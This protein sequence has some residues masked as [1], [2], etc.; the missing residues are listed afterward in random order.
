M[1]AMSSLKEIKAAW[2]E[3]VS[4]KERGELHDSALRFGRVS[5]LLKAEDGSSRIVQQLS[6]Q[7]EV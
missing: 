7:V 5:R 3:A 6:A 4:L 2:S 1:S